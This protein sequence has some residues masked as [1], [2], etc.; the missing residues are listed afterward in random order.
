VGE[1]DNVATWVVNLK[2][3]NDNCKSL[4]T[5][6]LVPKKVIVYSNPSTKQNNI[7]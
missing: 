2:K 4:R 6:P 3:N 5:T 1:P 7:E